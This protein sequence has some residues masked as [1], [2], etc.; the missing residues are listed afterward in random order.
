VRA[1]DPELAAPKLVPLADAVGRA[2]AVPR[3]AARV[4]S[5]FA[6]VALLLAALGLYGLVAHSVGRRT[7]EIGLRVT[8]GARPAD[9][10]RLVLR[11]G[12]LPAVVGTALGLAA[13]LGAARLLTRLLFGISPT[14]GVTLASAVA[15][16]VAVSLFAA[17]LPARRALAVEPAIVLRQD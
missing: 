13:A 8:L 14:D 4:F 7:R 5:A 1:H 6:L 16:L 17:A 15:L 2:L 10:V 9:V 11:E 12:L 3:F